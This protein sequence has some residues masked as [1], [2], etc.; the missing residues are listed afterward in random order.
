MNPALLF[1]GI[2]IAKISKM[3]EFNNQDTYLGILLMD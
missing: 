1:I 2:N 3:T